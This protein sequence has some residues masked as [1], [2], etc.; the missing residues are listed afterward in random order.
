[1]GTGLGASGLGIDGIEET[2]GDDFGATA[3]LVGAGADLGTLLGTTAV[4]DADKGLGK[5]LGATDC[6]GVEKGL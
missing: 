5:L 1:M 3:V 4:L 6:V 2:A